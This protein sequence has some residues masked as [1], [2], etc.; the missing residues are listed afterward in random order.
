M[1]GQGNLFLAVLFFTINDV[2]LNERTFLSHR[3][4]MTEK[5]PQVLKN[6]EMIPIIANR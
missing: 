5:R 4:E 2:F 6:A 3:R 1:E